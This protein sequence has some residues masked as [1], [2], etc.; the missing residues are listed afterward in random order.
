VKITTLLLLV[1][2]NPEPTIV[3][4]TIEPTVV[5]STTEPRIS[6]EVKVH[7]PTVRNSRR[8]YRYSAY[9][10]YDDEPQCHDLN[11]LISL[12]IF[13]TISLVLS[14]ST[15]F[16]ILVSLVICIWNSFDI[17][18]CLFSNSITCRMCDIFF[19]NGKLVK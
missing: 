1:I 7:Q 18:L 16:G 2:E 3:E 13:I 6:T 5:E 19:F 17:M 14:G 10:A 4:S 15:D 11:L 8:T 9:S 12:G